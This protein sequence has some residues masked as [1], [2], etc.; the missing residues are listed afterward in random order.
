MTEQTDTVSREEFEQL[1]NRVEE[2]ES[3]IGDDSGVP[4]TTPAGLDHRDMD[5]LAYMAEAH[6]VDGVQLVKL[7]KRLTDITA[8]STAKRRAKTLA[9]HPEYEELRQ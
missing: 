6:V 3:L 8:H 9:A 2:L 5:V 1:Q 4:N 7:Y